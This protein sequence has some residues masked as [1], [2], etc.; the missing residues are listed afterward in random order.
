MIELTERQLEIMS[1]VKQHAP[2]TGEQIAELL[3]VSRPTLRSDLALLVMLGHLDAKPKVGYFLGTKAAEAAALP[4]QWLERKVKDVQSLPVMVRATCTIHDAVVTLFLENVGS[5]IVSD[6]NGW[7]AGIV[8]RKDLLKVTIGNPNA[9]SMPVSLIM[10]RQP[11]IVTVLPDDSVPEAARR[12]IRHEV[13]AL[14][15]VVPV[16]DHPDALEVVG[17]ITKT[18]MTKMLLELTAG[19]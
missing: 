5:L 3:H 8:S 4:P 9:A 16:P 19:P 2:I 15:V 6:E 11:N 17:R 13:D 14:P 12:M 1:V 18:T 7:L 10:T